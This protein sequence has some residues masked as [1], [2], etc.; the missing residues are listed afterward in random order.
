[1]NKRLTD[2][3]VLQELDRLKKSP[4]VKLGRKA[5]KNDK[6]R[7]MLYALRYLE[8]E[9]KKVADVLGITYETEAEDGEEENV[10]N[11]YSGQ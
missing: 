6:A 2:E 1:M 3:E 5:R 9:G 11:G 7:Q 4:Y 8:K 10:L